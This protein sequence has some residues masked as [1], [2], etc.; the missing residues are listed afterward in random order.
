MFVGAILVSL[1]GSWRETPSTGATER[2]L[3][4]QQTARELQEK[5]F[6][7]VYISSRLLHSMSSVTLMHYDILFY[8]DM[9]QN[10]FTNIYSCTYCI[11]AKVSSFPMCYRISRGVSDRE[12]FVP[13]YCTKVN[14]SRRNYETI[15]D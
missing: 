6:V 4:A 1:T 10:I 8:E 2:Y 15:S 12:M 9:L 11:P 5:A 7:Y 3:A 13:I 14:I